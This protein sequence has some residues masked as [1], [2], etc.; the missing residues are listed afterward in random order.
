MKLTETFSNFKDAKK[1]VEIN[2]IHNFC[3]I[4]YWEENIKED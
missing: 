1:F 3:I 4:L 2:K